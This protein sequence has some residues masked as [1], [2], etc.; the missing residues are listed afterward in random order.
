[1]GGNNTCQGSYHS[2]IETIKA[3]FPCNVLFKYLFSLAIKQLRHFRHL[4][5]GLLNGDVFS[6]KS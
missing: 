2:E 1:M 3:F 5:L 6:L 4:L